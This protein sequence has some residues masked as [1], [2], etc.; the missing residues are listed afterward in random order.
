VNGTK[1]DSA[2][3]NLPELKAMFSGS[4]TTDPS[5]DGFG[6]RFRVAT[7]DVL[8]IDGVLTSRSNG[9]NDKLQ[10]NQKSQDEMQ[11]RLDQTQS[12]LTAQY[13][14]LDTK[15]GTLNSLSSY[16]TQQ[17]AQWNKA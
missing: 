5:L 3:A 8:G 15:L 6:K 13:T 14:A 7:S 1:L 9:L 17:V 4:S 16:V 2:L 10:R 12:R 11:A